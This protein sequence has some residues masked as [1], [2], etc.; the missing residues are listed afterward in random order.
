MTTLTDINGIGPA[1]ARRLES[2]GITTIGQVASTP[3]DVLAEVQGVSAA[4]A[5]QIIANATKVEDVPQDPNPVE[6]SE[7]VVDVAT[8]PVEIKSEEV[9]LLE[10]EVKKLEAKVVKLKKALVKATKVSKGKP[11]KSKSSK[12][13]RSKGNKKSKK[14]K[15]K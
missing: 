8:A 15:K 1:L 5:V 7:P 2:A 6:E 9:E 3:P 11:S 12:G 13:K 4:S 14:R 10:A